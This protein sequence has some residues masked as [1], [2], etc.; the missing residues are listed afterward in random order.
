MFGQIRRERARVAWQSRRLRDAMIERAR[1]IGRLRGIVE[2]TSVGAVALTLTLGASE[3]HQGRA[4][5]GTVVAAMTVLGMLMPAVRDLGRVHEYWHGY[6][7]AREKLSEFLAVKP[8]VF[9][10]SMPGA[11]ETPRGEI[12]FRD[13]SVAGSLQGVSC[14]AK[15]GTRVVITGPN[16]SGKSTLLNLV[17]RMLDPDRGQ[18][19]IDGRDVAGLAL[20][21]I[22]Q[23]VGM[24]SPDLCLL[25][26]TIERNLRYRWPDAPEE[27]VAQVSRLCGI[28]P[29]LD[30]M[31]LGG[32]TKVADGGANLSVG[33][34]QRIALA[35]ALLGAPPIL[36][37]D[38]ADANL[39]AD[40]S[41]VLNTA[42]AQYKGTVL[43]VS[44]RPERIALADIVWR[45]EDGRLSEEPVI[46][47]P[48]SPHH[49]RAAA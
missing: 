1:A 2:A 36:L 28:E 8:Q 32:Q 43:F 9:Q 33:Q 49:E 44:H 22:R 45:I 48:Q 7:V 31:P 39:D 3:F 14:H 29:M 26:G 27:D 6:A 4:S 41:R 25:R 12:E 15:P 40:S 34:R 38:E 10:V 17:V 23:A 35:R 46:D 5:A 42:L 21:S 24:V 47:S 30:A 37:L 20:A 13:V 18:I 16:G 11:L 19:F